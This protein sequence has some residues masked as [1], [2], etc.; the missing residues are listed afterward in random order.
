MLV[1]EGSHQHSYISEDTRDLMQT[2]HTGENSV[3]TIEFSPNGSLLAAVNSFEL[4]QIW[5]LSDGQVMGELNR[6]APNLVD[7]LAFSPDG[8]RL[9]AG[10]YGGRIQVWRLHDG[11][12]ERTI[13]SSIH[14][15]RQLAFTPDGG[16]LLSAYGTYDSVKL[17]RVAN[18]RLQQRFAGDSFHL[19]PDGDS[20]ATNS[21]G[22][23]VDFRQLEDRRLLHTLSSATDELTAMAVSSDGRFVVVTVTE[24][25]G[26]LRFHRLADGQ[27]LCRTKAHRVNG[28]S[29][30]L[31][32]DN[33]RLASVGFDGDI[34][35][36]QLPQVQQLYLLG[37][38]QREWMATFS[39]S[40]H[41]LATGMDGGVLR[42]WDGDSGVPIG[43]LPDHR[44]WNNRITFTPD[45]AYLAAATDSGI[46][47][48]HTGSGQLAHRVLASGTGVLTFSADGSLL[49]ANTWRGIRVWRLGDQTMIYE[50]DGHSNVVNDISFSPDGRLLASASADGTLRLWR[51]DDGKPLAV[52]RG[53]A[54][55][56]VHAVAFTSNGF[57]LLSAGGDG[58]IAVW[59]LTAME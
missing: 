28:H 20:L 9:A 45:D 56:T 18:G 37:G 8:E 24:R 17:W 30:S 15:V 2:I 16:S 41:M 14:T 29:L 47:I 52:L 44:A 42:L 59:G 19:S 13:R 11:R 12:R 23:H 21:F 40:G 7:S 3:R 55:S 5:R 1:G 43:Q 48:W 53:H 35:V 10:S 25:N 22:Q 33:S 32:A 6:G 4:I 38:R 34:R 50:S 39:N 46:N 57:L 26:L 51:A 58:T 36:W 27:L 54:T 49:A 31:T